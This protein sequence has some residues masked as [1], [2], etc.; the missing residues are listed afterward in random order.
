MPSV[1]QHIGGTQ[2]VLMNDSETNVLS[3]CDCVNV[4]LWAC[5][6]VCLQSAYKTKVT[7]MSR[8]LC[9][10]VTFPFFIISPFFFMILTKCEFFVKVKTRVIKGYPGRES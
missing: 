6:E 5:L 8:F 10:T 9:K 1:F 3:T 2:S 4:C 7:Y